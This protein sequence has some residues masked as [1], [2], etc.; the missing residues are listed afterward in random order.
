MPSE[1]Q[2]FALCIASR[3]WLVHIVQVLHSPEGVSG[4]AGA[5]LLSAP[6]VRAAVTDMH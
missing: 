3:A 2:L 5:L 6:P 1:A 4:V